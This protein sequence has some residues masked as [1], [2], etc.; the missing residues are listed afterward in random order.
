MDARQ[1]LG[2]AYNGE[3][4]NYKELRAELEKRGEMLSE[5]D[6]EV[7]L[8]GFLRQGESFFS[9]MRGMWAV[10]IYDPAKKTVTLSRDPFGIKPL[11]Y[12][13]DEKGFAFSSEMKALNLY[14]RE[15]RI[16]LHLSRIGCASY[17]TLGYAIHPHTVFEEIK[18][19]EP[20][21]VMTL[22]LSDGK[23]MSTKIKWKPTQVEET[24]EGVLRDSVR[25]HLI[26]EVPVGVFLSGGVDSTLIALMLKKVGIPLHAFTVD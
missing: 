2:I 23:T 20:G 24:L 9:K 7:I 14:C 11:Y 21:V 6:T 26:A 16:K 10:A 8:R 17:F 4:Y 15:K 3:I 19:F 13:K 1:R 18:K 22:S 12:L 5:S 25:H